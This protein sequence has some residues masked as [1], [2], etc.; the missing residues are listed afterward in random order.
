MMNLRTGQIASI[1]LRT[2]DGKD[3]I[4]VAPDDECRRIVPAEVRMPGV[5]A[6]DIA[7]IIGVQRELNILIS[8]P[9]E[10]PLRVFP[11]IGAN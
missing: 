11:R 8:R 1:C 2:L 9:L 4:T 5:V 3:G 10:T 6:L 7:S